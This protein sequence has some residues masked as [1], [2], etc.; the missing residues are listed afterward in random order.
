MQDHDQ[1]GR[2]IADRVYLGIVTAY[3]VA[4]A[5]SG[6]SA[7][8]YVRGTYITVD[9]LLLSAAALAAVLWNT[10]LAM[11][12]V[13]LGCVASIWGASLNVVWP[14]YFSEYLRWCASCA[15]CLIP[16]I[17]FATMVLSLKHVERKLLALLCS[18]IPALVITAGAIGIGSWGY[19]A[20]L[21]IYE[22]PYK[23]GEHWSFIQYGLHLPLLY[24][25]ASISV[26]LI[27]R[28]GLKPNVAYP[29]AIG[30]FL[31]SFL[32][33]PTINLFVP[34]MQHFEIP[35]WPTV[36]LPPVPSYN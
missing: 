32:M 22:V 34:A 12:M 5:F 15:G 17:A 29:L 21:S 30:I 24:I 16:A 27:C 36:S 18:V 33:I 19:A 2:G 26:F 4:L 28:S 10:K 25:A 9:N 35:P 11:A 14:E 23:V 13:L 6:A 20:F 3:A 31:A 8:P 1:R 7:L